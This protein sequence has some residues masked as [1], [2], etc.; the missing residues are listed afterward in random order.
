MRVMLTPKI[1]MYG[2]DMKLICENGFYKFFPSFVGEV[3]LWENKNGIKLFKVRDFWTFE[4]LASF[5]NYSFAGQFVFGI[6]PAL[7]NYAGSPEEV[8]AKNQLTY[9][10]KL[11]T[12]T[13]RAMVVLQRLN[14]ANGAYLTFPNIP[15]AFALD[16]DLQPVSGFEAFIDVRLNTY[17]IERLIYENI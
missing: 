1:Q 12:I 16:Q 14:Y 6:I 9:N 8:L 3:K 17:K 15:Q 4:S 2:L 11:G 13:P 10:V 5:P 7:V